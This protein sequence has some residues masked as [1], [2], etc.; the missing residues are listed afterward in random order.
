VAARDASLRARGAASTRLRNEASNAE[1]TAL[2]LA[3]DSPTAHNGL[4]LLAVDQGRPE[5]AVHE[6]QR[7][8]ELDPNNAGYWA[9]LGNARRAIGDRADAEGAYR[10]ALD[11]DRRAA[12]A[13]NGLGVL[14]VEEQRASE[15]V[16]WLERAAASPDF[17]EAR[18]NLGIA[19]QQSGQPARAADVYRSVLAA[20][21]R[22]KRERTAA[23]KLLASLP[24]PR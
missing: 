5:D 20:P 6:F 15:A 13:A 4:G 21:V 16:E 24:A 12:D 18:L 10:R 17:I 9:N 11:V 3:P 22:Y 19:L 14:L 2:T 1:R 8:A 7:A 23:K